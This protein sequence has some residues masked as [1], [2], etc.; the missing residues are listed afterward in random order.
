MCIWIDCKAKIITDELSLAIDALHY[1]S[2]I[3]YN[4]I[5]LVWSATSQLHVPWFLLAKI[6]NYAIIE[7]GRK[8]GL[9]RR[10][11]LSQEHNKTHLLNP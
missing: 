3:V 4:I 2:N 6:C 11:T 5:A 10:T 8:L 1:S 9:A 7:A